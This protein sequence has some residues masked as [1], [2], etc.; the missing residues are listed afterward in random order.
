MYHELQIRFIFVHLFQHLLSQCTYA[1]LST[2]RVHGQYL[3]YN[4]FVISLKVHCNLFTGTLTIWST[5]HKI[6]ILNISCMSQAVFAGKEIGKWLIS[7]LVKT[8]QMRN[9]SK[10]L[11]FCSTICKTIVITLGRKLISWTD[12]SNAVPSRCSV[13]GVAHT[14]QLCG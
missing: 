14:G 2:K 10:S 8:F 1:I 13:L 6:V 4:S 7:H 12:N 5:H 9:L 3:W 11:S